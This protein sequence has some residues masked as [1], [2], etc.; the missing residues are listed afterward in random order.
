M[1]EI[2]WGIIGCGDV[3]EVKSGPAFSA[4]PGS[5]LVA[6]MRRNGEKAA[7]Y[8]R[9][10]GVPRWYDDAQALIDDPEV[11]AVYIAT[12]PGSHC[13]YALRVAAAGKPCYVEK[14]MARNASECWRMVE[15]FESRGLL[16]F[17]AYYRRALP[18]FVKAR[19]LLAEGAIGRLSGIGYRYASAAHRQPR[20]RLGWR[21]DPAESGGGLFLDLGS[22]LL[23]VLDW[24]IGPLEDVTGV[25]R[26]V[27]GTYAVEDS[28]SMTFTAGGACGSASWNF[29]SDVAEDVI[30]LTGTEGRITWSCF[31]RGEVRLTRGQETEVF[32]L[33]APR[34]VHQPLVEQ[35]VAQLRGGEVSPSTGRSAMRTSVIMDTVLAGY[36]QG[37]KDAFWERANWAKRHLSCANAY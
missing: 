30:E 3:T 5:R 8:A 31:G 28:V 29:A 4:V 7:D 23:D 13:D 11:D 34:T 1:K 16:L 12:P 36:Y 32:D 35:I 24:I 37:R 2:G 21:I 9:R 6:V 27:S 15:A 33:P 17:V 19:S 20:E 14:P 25:A 10:H 26:N 18:A 22:H